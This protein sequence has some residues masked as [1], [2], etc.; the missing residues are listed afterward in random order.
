MNEV[1][2]NIGKIV[3]LLVKL[4]ATSCIGFL[5]EYIKDKTGNNDISKI[6]RQFCLFYYRGQFF[7]GLPSSLHTITL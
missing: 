4:H 3:Q 1:P 6:K 5:I 2:K 7:P